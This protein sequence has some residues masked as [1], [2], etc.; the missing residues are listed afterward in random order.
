MQ[1]RERENNGLVELP[2]MNFRNYNKIKIIFWNAN[3]IS[4]KIKEFRN[5]LGTH[6]PEI[7]G[8]TETKLKRRSAPDIAGYKC[9]WRNRPNGRGGGLALYA[10]NDIDVMEIPTDTAEIESLALKIGDRTYVLVYKRPNTV[11]LE[12]GIGIGTIQQIIRLVLF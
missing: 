6:K 1:K 8:I 3:G 5:F 4:R 12:D 11:L 2:K 10:S 7:V 9:I